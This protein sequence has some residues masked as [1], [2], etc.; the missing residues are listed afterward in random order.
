MAMVNGNHENL[1]SMQHKS[2]NTTRKKVSKS[3]TFNTAVSSSLPTSPVSPRRRPSKQL[4]PE[5]RLT[6]AVYLLMEA[7]RLARELEGKKVA[8][9]FFRPFTAKQSSGQHSRSHAASDGATR[10]SSA[11]GNRFSRERLSERKKALNATPKANQRYCAECQ[12][13]LQDGY[14]SQHNGQ[15]FCNV[16]CYPSL[17][18]T[19]VERKDNGQDSPTLDDEHILLRKK[20]LPKL[21]TYNTYYINRPCQISCREDGGKLVVEGVLKIYWGVVKPVTLQ[22]SD[23]SYWKDFRP[24]S[25]SKV[26]SEQNNVQSKSQKIQPSVRRSKSGLSSRY[27]PKKRV[28]GGYD[29]IRSTSH[30]NC[31]DTVETNTLNSPFVRKRI[32]CS[33]CNRFIF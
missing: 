20:L 26:V 19:L 13:C 1:P 27:L 28:N 7:K 33:V 23:I 10:P 6:K 24:Q 12:E 3:N 30:Q 31:R 15:L 18:S 5:P 8:G 29:V 22:E 9:S 4:P 17:F 16:P 32:G 11:L 14:Y 21:R 2:R 25:G